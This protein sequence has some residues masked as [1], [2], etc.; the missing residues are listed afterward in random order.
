VR[1]FL[2]LIEYNTMTGI[3]LIAGLGNPGDKYT[4]TRHNA[5]FWFVDLLAEQSN[6]RLSAEAKLF[7]IAGKW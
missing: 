4:L 6:S 7:G 5:G 2:C 1:V 3:K